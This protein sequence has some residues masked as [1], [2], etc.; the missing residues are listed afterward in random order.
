MYLGYF[1][2]Q[3]G[4]LLANLTLGNLIK[5][6]VTWTVQVLRIR[7]E[8]KFLLNDSAYRNLARQVKFRLVPGVY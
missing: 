3:V 8:E 2:T 5:Y 6:L 7:E 4:F 1:V